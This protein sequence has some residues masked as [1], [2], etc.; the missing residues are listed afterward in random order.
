MHCMRRRF[1]R[2]ILSYVTSHTVYLRAC[3]VDENWRSTR[4]PWFYNVH[5][6]RFDKPT[7]QLT[8]YRWSDPAAE[9]KNVTTAVKTALRTSVTIIL[10]VSPKS[11][12]RFPAWF[13]SS[14]PS[15]SPLSSTPPPVFPLKCQDKQCLLL[16]FMAGK[17]IPP[18]TSWKILCML[19]FSACLRA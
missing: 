18:M 14:R 3:A 6:F 7:T 5:P 2:S 1:Y 9:T 17:R 19:Y 8:E 12:R 11:F 15:P 4:L 13:L 16:R 10:P